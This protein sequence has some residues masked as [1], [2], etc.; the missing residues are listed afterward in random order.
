MKKL[1]VLMSMILV[2]TMAVGGCAT[3]KNWVCS[4]RVTIENYITAAQ[5]TIN[6]IMA[7]FPGVIPPAAQAV[8]AAA[9]LVI[10]A[11]TRL[12]DNNFCPTAADVQTVAALQTDMRGKTA[13]FG[14]TMIGGR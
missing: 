10:D 9:N 3:V 1:L 8:I 2:L 7:E 13:E 11:G 14:R 6:T 5:A 4:N 12:L